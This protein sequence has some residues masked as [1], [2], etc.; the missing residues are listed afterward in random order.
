MSESV[1]DVVSDAAPTRWIGHMHR[2]AQPHYESAQDVL[3]SLRLH[4]PSGRSSPPAESTDD[5]I[6]IQTVV[7][8]M[9]RIASPAVHRRITCS[10]SITLTSR[11]AMHNQSPR[12]ARHTR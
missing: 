2:V 12:C 6:A 5:C 10:I 8:A 3:L 11:Y 7:R 4:Q 9:A 1:S